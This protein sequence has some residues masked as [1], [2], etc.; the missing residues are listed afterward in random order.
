MS[1]EIP[2]V[3]WR[4]DPEAAELPLVFDSPHSGSHYPEDFRFACPLEH[5]RRAE[6]AYVDELYADAPAHGATLIGALFPRSYLDPNRGVED[7]DEALNRR[8]MANTSEA[9]AKDALRTRLGATSS[10][11]Q[12]SHL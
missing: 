12:H 8:Q 1:F 2:G 5:L 9:V 11:A 6:D 10:A 3:L 4:R 7:I